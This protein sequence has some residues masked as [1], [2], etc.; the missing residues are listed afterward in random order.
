[1]KHRTEKEG[2]ALVERYNSSGKSRAGFA[3]HA[4]V[5]RHVLSYWIGRVQKLD[6]GS[7]TNRFVEVTVPKTEPS[8]SVKISVGGVS[9]TLANLPPAAWIAEFV[10]LVEP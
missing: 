8:G 3:R 9:I 4:R 6:S 5:K 1:M 7:V 2:R 10:G